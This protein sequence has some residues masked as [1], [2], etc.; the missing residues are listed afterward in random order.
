MRF[1]FSMWNFLFRWTLSEN[2]HYYIVNIRV[3]ECRK[4]HLTFHLKGKKTSGHINLGQLSSVGF[5]GNNSLSCLLTFL[6]HFN[7]QYFGSSSAF[8]LLIVKVS[9]QVCL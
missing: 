3:N 5:E 8:H 1:F 7:L 4:E 6:K 2:F 9:F